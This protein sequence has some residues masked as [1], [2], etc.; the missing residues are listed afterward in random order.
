M[1]SQ[2]LD[3]AMPKHYMRWSFET[4]W[5]AKQTL[6]REMKNELMMY[7]ASYI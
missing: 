2:V 3:K 4:I 6:E 7:F 5:Y 1:E